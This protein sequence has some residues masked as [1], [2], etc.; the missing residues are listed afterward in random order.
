MT[1]TRTP[2]TFVHALLLSLLFAPGA[3]R[4][5]VP[6]SVACAAT[7]TPDPE[8]D[9]DCDGLPDHLEDANQNGRVDLGETDPHKR[10]TDGDGASDM[11][12]YLA[13][14]DANRDA[15][16][17]FPEPMVFDLVRGLDSERGELEFNAL[18][19]LRPRSEGML[20]Q[21]APEMEYAFGDGMAAE[22][23][24]P[25]E[26]ERVAALKSALQ[27]TFHVDPH[28]RWAH[29]IQVLAEA[30]LREKETE[31]ALLHIGK[32]RAGERVSLISISGVQGVHARQS[33]DVHAV[34]LVNLSA[35]Y[36]VA[37]QVIVGVE[38]NLRLD[39]A[40]AFDWLVMPQ[41]HVQLN[42]HA[43]MQV[44]LG[45]AKGG[46]SGVEPMLSTRFIIEM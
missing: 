21:Y 29:G 40:L 8:Q 2:P 28:R 4:A 39:D 43:R 5:W 15:F 30:K 44:G 36:A 33:G 23:E 13:G 11:T 7:A 35:F 27:F 19:R 12:E 18:L 22:L 38:T 24:L 41:A 9:S 10:D 45:A 20:L 25:M 34:G 16:L 37:Q 31:L 32:V 1:S 14:T 3:A 42:H 46:P 6:S 26:N 17:S